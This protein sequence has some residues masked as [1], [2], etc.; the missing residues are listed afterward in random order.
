V[1]YDYKLFI[2]EIK[3]SEDDE[4]IFSATGGIGRGYPDYTP[5]GKMHNTAHLKFMAFTLRPYPLGKLLYLYCEPNE[6]CIRNIC[7]IIN[8]YFIFKA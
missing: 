5:T 4:H 1:K 8:F 6:C 3:F 2:D 7:K